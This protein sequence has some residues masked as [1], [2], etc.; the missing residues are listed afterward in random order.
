[1]NKD[2]FV[3][4]PYINKITPEDKKLLQKTVL[5]LRPN[6]KN[7]E[8]SW[9]YIIQ[10]TR[11]GGFKWYDKKTNSLIFFGKKSAADST[12]VVPLF[13]CEID[14]LAKVVSQIQQ[15]MKLTKIVL[16]NVNS[17]EV[18]PLASYGF[19]KYKKNE[20]WSKESRFDDQTYPQLVVDLKKVSEA[21]GKLYHHLRKALRKNPNADIRKYLDSDKKA[22]LKIFAA[23]DGNSKKAT[24]G[25]YYSSH[26]M[27]VSADV[28]KFVITDNNTG[29][30]I[31]FTATSAITPT[32]T[33][34][35]ALLFKPK[36]KIA[37]V[38][39]I[40]QTMMLQYKKG[41]TTI[42]FGGC[43]TE[44]TYNFAQRTFRPVIELEKTHLIYEN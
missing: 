9:G 35:V 40:Y 38:W 2:D 20:G 10:A 3:L 21:K 24:T 18:L 1:M 39:G 31:G 6:S 4:S 37:S 11:N 27:Y 44:G 36:V 29:N 16:K 19:R 17:D 43:E 15:T 14:Y 8:D 30:I 41:F 7:Y 42:N 23:K 22:V 34:F 26:H 25:K 33:A 5:R 13:L 32:S 28:D 12:L